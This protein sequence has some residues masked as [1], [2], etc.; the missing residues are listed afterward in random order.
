MTLDQAMIEVAREFD[1]IIEGSSYRLEVGLIGAGF[2][3]VHV[4][5][6]LEHAREVAEAERTR[7]LQYVRGELEAWL[8]LERDGDTQSR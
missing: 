5:Q 4:E 1:A 2:C 6:M 3:P 8:G 7:V